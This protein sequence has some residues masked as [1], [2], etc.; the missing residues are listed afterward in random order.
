MGVVTVNDT[1]KVSRQNWDQASVQSIM[2][3]LNQLRSVSPE[4]PALKALELM[5]RE[6]LNQLGVISNGELLG[7]FSRAQVLRFLQL[8]AGVGEDSQNAA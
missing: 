1:A 4:M 7:I 5:S 3:P 6:N 8:H 2:R